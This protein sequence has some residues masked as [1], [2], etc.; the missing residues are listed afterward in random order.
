MDTNIHNFVDDKTV[1]ILQNNSSSFP[2]RAYDFH[3]HKVLI[4]KQKV[5][6]TEEWKEFLRYQ[7][8]RK[9]K[10]VDQESPTSL[11][12]LLLT[13][14]WALQ[15][16]LLPFMSTIKVKLKTWKSVWMS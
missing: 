5:F 16:N 3:N 10:R 6:S 15:L 2:S 14:S 8:H 12:L 11:R 7:S 9:H 4:E 13:M 1:P